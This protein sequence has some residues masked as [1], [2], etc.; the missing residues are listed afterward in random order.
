MTQ[1]KN[2]LLSY[3]YLPESQDQLQISL[4]CV[5]TV[6]TEKIFPRDIH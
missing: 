1:Y 6:K 4:L 5:N 2:Y 3:K